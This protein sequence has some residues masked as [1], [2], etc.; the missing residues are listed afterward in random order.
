MAYTK[1][2]LT[3]AVE[4][5]E[6][7]LKNGAEIYRVEDTINHILTSYDVEEFDVY[8][9]SNGIFASANENREDACSIVRHVPL[10]SVNLG[11]ISALN[12]LARDICEHKISLIDSWDEL[13]RCKAIP[14][15][16]HSLLTLCCGLGSGCFCYLFGGGVTD[17]LIA[18]G[19]GLLEEQFIVL[20][21]KYKLSKIV[22]NIL[23]SLFV[24]LMAYICVELGTLIGA[25]YLLRDKIIIGAI[26][27]LVPG[28]A[29]TT[30]IRD[31]YN[32]DYLSGIIHLLDAVITAVAIAVGA[33]LPFM[34]I[35]NFGGF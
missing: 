33:C 22:S 35:R 32:G 24:A 34:I 28:I 6:T 12:Q 31:V 18:F 9:L 7:M 13:D 29:F 11:K 8:V 4:I 23:T 10:G 16:K 17:S 21:S 1:E 26:M 2:I 15:Y 20:F 14:D 27:P 3:L 5:G 25:D 19:I 30:A